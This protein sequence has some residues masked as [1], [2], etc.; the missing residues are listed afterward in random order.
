MGSP[1]LSAVLA[2][3]YSWIEIAR[4]SPTAQIRKK[5]GLVA[6]VESMRVVYP[7]SHKASRGHG[8]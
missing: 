1:S 8:H 7:T 6:R 2:W 3:A 4:I 5:R